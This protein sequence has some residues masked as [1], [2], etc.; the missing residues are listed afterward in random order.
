MCTRHHTR[1]TWCVYGVFI[2]LHAHMCVFMVLC[3]HVLELD[4]FLRCVY[5]VFKAFRVHILELDAFISL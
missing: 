5:G 2:V 1:L 4:A 3:V